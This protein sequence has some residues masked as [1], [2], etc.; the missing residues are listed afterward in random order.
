MTATLS[1]RKRRQ[2]VSTSMLFWTFV[3]M[4]LGTS[5]ALR[6]VTVQ[7]P[8]RSAPRMLMMETPMPTN[9]P[10]ER[11]P[12]SPSPSALVQP[13]VLQLPTA[14]PSEEP[15]ANV[16]P[17]PSKPPN[18]PRTDSPTSLP[19]TPPSP[20]P[21]T[22]V[23]MADFRIQYV[24]LSQENPE[25]EEY[26]MEA[27]TQEYLLQRMQRDY[28]TLK[29]I[30]LLVNPRRNL[31]TST[32]A[33]QI[34]YSGTAYFDSQQ[35][36]P[37]VRQV[38]YSQTVA[39]EDTEALQLSFEMAG[40]SVQVQQVEVAPL[41]EEPAPNTNATNAGII[42]GVTIGAVI[43]VGLLAFA[44]YKWYST[45]KCSCLN[46][47]DLDKDTSRD[48]DKDDFVK[49]TPD[50]FEPVQT[51]QTDDSVGVH[52]QSSVDVSS[53]DMDEYSLSAASADSSVKRDP[54]QRRESLLKKLALYQ[55]TER[56]P[57][58]NGSNVPMPAALFVPQVVGGV[59]DE[60]DSVAS[61]AVFS[62]PR[63]PDSPM[64]V[65][66]SPEQVTEH[67]RAVSLLDQS[68]MTNDDSTYDEYDEEDL[69]PPPVPV[70]TSRSPEWAL[71]ESPGQE[72]VPSTHGMQSQWSLSP[73][74]QAGEEN[75]ETQIVPSVR[76]AQLV[77]VVAFDVSFFYSH[78]FLFNRHTT[79]LPR[80]GCIPW[81]SSHLARIVTVR[82][83]K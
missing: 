78:L 66:D 22:P 43:I 17:K 31:Q 13:V 62:S 39:L 52:P 36:V 45:R 40:L 27:V 77:N 23:T 79:F 11:P 15:T 67:S 30:G 75:V 3:C 48:H 50:D 60:E 59:N 53:V 21:E 83:M 5:H 19:T 65:M 34:A 82:R 73:M 12:P 74:Q 38:Q 55:K 18:L 71:E 72:L 33:S 81:H 57:H 26:G 10:T 51:S 41:P 8:P 80:H 28:N 68:G 25:N 61:S 29:R 20:A 1:M 6:G 69:L 9:S 14:T 47:I 64:V 76:W 46:V 49:Y 44:G 24:S 70:S 4:L 16:T 58:S 37:S 56:K 35:P 2:C 54:E 63:T 32:L 7:H 42:A